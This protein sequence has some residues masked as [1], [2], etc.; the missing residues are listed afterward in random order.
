MNKILFM[1]FYGKCYRLSSYLI[2]NMIMHTSGG[3]INVHP[4]QKFH[5]ELRIE[6]PKTVNHETTLHRE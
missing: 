2:M 5:P 3:V 6:K 4:G 1:P